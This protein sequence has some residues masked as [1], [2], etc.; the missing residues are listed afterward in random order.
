MN[1]EIEKKEIESASPKNTTPI[2]NVNHSI[3][4]ECRTINSNKIVFKPIVP[5]SNTE[6]CDFKIK[7]LE[8]KIIDFITKRKNENCFVVIENEFTTLCKSPTMICKAL[9]ALESKGEIFKQ[10]NGWSLK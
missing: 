10:N 3:N 2:N 5:S 8:K 4:K 6:D 9:K 1:S 7:M